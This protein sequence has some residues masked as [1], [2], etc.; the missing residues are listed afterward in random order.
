MKK[1]I[2]ALGITAE[3]IGGF[4]AAVIVSCIIT[5]MVAVLGFGVALIIELFWGQ[6]VPW[7][8]GAKL[9]IIIAFLVGSLYAAKSWIT[10]ACLNY[11]IRLIGHREREQAALPRRGWN[12]DDDAALARLAKQKREQAKQKREQSK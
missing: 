9:V 6:Q 12:D 8:I 4:V 11:R 7:D 10:R 3:D 2:L 5:A 1:Y